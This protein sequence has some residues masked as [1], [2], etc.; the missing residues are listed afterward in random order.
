M[1]GAA[2]NSERAPDASILHRFFA[3][4]AD[5]LADDDPALFAIL[6][7]EYA[8]Q[9]DTLALV[10]SCSPTHPT[11]LVCEGSF[12]SNVTAEGYPGRRFHAGC[13]NV[14][15]I[16]QLAIDRA[17]AAFGARYAN[18]Q[19][20]TASVAN[21]AVF[22]ALLQPGDALLGLDLDAGGHLSH[23]ASVNLSGKLYRAASYGLTAA[24][25]ID[26]DQVRAVALATRPRLIIAGTTAYPRAL[27]WTKF[28]AIADEV[29]ALLLADIT[30]IAGLVI[31]GDHPSPLDVAHIVT[32]CTHKQLYGPRGG[33]ILLGADADA[34]LPDGGTLRKAMQRAVF[35]LVQGA[36]IV[37]SIAAK[38]CALG[39]AQQPAFRALM[40]RVVDLA[41]ALAAAMMANG[42]RVM[43][44][45]TD[46]HIVVI[47]VLTSHGLTGIVAEKA[48]EDCGLI[49]NKNRIAG[50]TKPPT[51][52][53]GIRIGSNSMAARTMDAAQMTTIAALIDR[54]LGSVSM[55]D[56]RTYRLADAVRADV[57]TQVRALCTSNPIADYV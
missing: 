21:Q 50:D 7:R 26:Y 38:A 55:L 41:R 19:P 2:A 16:E 14:D 48:L 1:T 52:G 4:A 6:E 39:R 23:G 22:S 44:N 43:A 13:V 31:S 49:V 45:G 34:P 30:H 54:V 10:A 15:A 25:L 8:R 40:R 42:A 37:N 36:P 53:S 57:Q 11:A 3:A 47:D 35:P 5:R 32:T 33:L 28:R 18:V 24:G 20:H 51:V 9:R 12:A 56:D 17:C 29:G 46:N 27:D